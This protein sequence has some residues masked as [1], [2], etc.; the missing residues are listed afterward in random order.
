MIKVYVDWSVMS[1]LKQGHHPELLPYLERKGQL[2]VIY[3]TSHISD[4]LVSYREGDAQQD[5]RIREDLDFI[6]RLTDDWCAHTADKQIVIRPLDPHIQFEEQ[7]EQSEGYGSEGPLAYLLNLLERGSPA[8]QALEAYMQMP[9]PEDM[10]RVYDEPGAAA[11]MRARYPG[12]E[13][14]PTIGMLISSFWSSRKSLN[15]TEAYKDL[16]L[17]LQQG[18]G[19]NKDKMFASQAPFADMAKIY[20]QIRELTGFDIDQVM[21]NDQTPAWFQDISHNYLLLDMHGFQQDKVKVSEKQKDTM[22]NTVDDGF[23]A[24][25]ASTCDFYL[26]SDSRS[27]NKA[28]AVYEKLNLNTRIWSPAEFV[29]YADN[30]LAYDAPADHLKLWLRLLSTEDYNESTADDG[31]WRTILTEFFFFD[32]FNK[33]V[34]FYENGKTV[35]VI[36]LTKIKPSNYRVISPQEVTAV[37]SK[38]NIAFRT[39]EATQ[40]RTEDFNLSGTFSYTWQFEGLDYRLHYL[41]GFLQLYLDLPEQQDS[42]NV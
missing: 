22:R 34:L 30:S 32:Y 39:D 25:F 29:A 4:I 26:T 9:M 18:L 42:S 23:H 19:I 8:G 20:E 35:P 6:S 31:I 28:K 14:D 41:N 33:I 38:L 10:V 2:V 12:L 13:E 36:Y 15:E 5:Q 40:V 37:I 21:R 24:A 17:D 16:R 7:V 1:Q 27:A 3:S 11:R